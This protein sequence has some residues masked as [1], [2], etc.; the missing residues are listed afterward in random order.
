MTGLIILLIL[1]PVIFLFLIISIYSKASAQQQ[2]METVYDKLK[3]LSDQFQELSG[4]LKERQESVVIK[5]PIEGQVSAQ[6]SFKK[7][8]EAVFQKKEIIKETF[9][10]PVAKEIKQE[11]GKEFFIPKQEKEAE[12][13]ATLE[14]N[15]NRYKNTGQSNADLEKFIGENLANKIGIAVLVLG[16][17]FFVKY[18]IDKNWIR[19]TG[20]VIIGLVSG[21]ILML[22]AH[23]IRN[24]Y[25]SFSSV[26][27][28]GGLTVFYFTIAFAFHQYHLISQQAA[29]IIMVIIT[30]SGVMMSL[31]YNRLELSILATVGGFITPFLVSTGQENYIAL[32]IYLCILNGGLMVLAWFK[33]WP[34]IKFIAL[35]FTII[36]FGSW[37]VKRLWFDNPPD[38][39]HKPALLFASL[40]YLQF[41]TMNIINNLR[42]KKMFSAFDFI[43]VFSINFLY[44]AAG[45]LALEYW[46]GG[47]HKGLFTASL[48]LFNLLLA[49][50]FYRSKNVDRNFVYLLIGLTLSFVSLFAPVQLQGNHITLF[51]AA[52]MVVLFWL[53]QRS[54][55]KLIK[56]AS[57]L[58]AALM[59]ISLLIDW[60]NIYFSGHKVIPVFINQG[61][62]TSITV[63]AALFI[64]QLFVHKQANSYYLKGI[65]NTF[66]KSGFLICSMLVLY[67]A[68][69]L[70]I[71]YQF[72]TRY[73]IQLF[74]I[75]LQLYTFAAAVVICWVLRH[76]KHIGLMQVLFTT[77]C[78][79]F[80]LLNIRTNYELSF[81]IFEKE[82][83]RHH[84]TA[85]WLA[86][87]LLFKLLFDLITFFRKNQITWSSYQ[88][89]FTWLSVVSII[90]LLSIEAYHILVWTNYQHKENWYYAENLFFKAGLT[91]LWAICSFI[92]I[93]A[94]MKYH[95][96]PLRIISLTLFTVILVKLFSYDISNIPPG[97]KIAAF[98]L[99]GILL[100]IVSFMY[101]RLKKII[102]DDA[103]GEKTL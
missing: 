53:Y 49:F 40:F 89:P 91:I 94:G 37:L 28:G 52:E 69:V 36:I 6:P 19:E 11:P 29:F 54:G 34:A 64:Y 68:G 83:L 58:I 97:G 82:N 72:S 27:V 51:W 57:V 14:E 21:G 77:L 73:E 75:Y 71:Y 84:F 55:L 15:I 25:R 100:L 22:L 81:L 39:P 18:A 66:V 10:P 1:I 7:E 74:V 102:I 45:M 16:I 38:L 98:I 99:L 76:S 9:Q 87:L 13:L 95:F 20:R 35:F 90:T 42:L 65:A 96:R 56:I 24:T 103:A 3:Q 86:A 70:E 46:S 26:L 88:A 47:K 85:H 12:E 33:R 60:T 61:F 2:L 32:F 101:Q 17:A 50:I 67:L 4:K 59:L 63:A 8:E 43:I 78:F 62:V 44:Y 79:T 30:A 41:V 23:R 48:G 80:Y 5:E 93:W 31:F 92:M